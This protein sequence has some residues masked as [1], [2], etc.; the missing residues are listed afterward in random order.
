MCHFTSCEFNTFRNNPDQISDRWCI[1]HTCLLT[2]TSDTWLKLLL[3][4]QKN[5]L[6]K[7]AIFYKAVVISTHLRGATSNA[8]FLKLY[9]I[10]YFC[11]SFQLFSNILASFRR[12]DFIPTRKGITEILTQNRQGFCKRRSKSFIEKLSDFIFAGDFGHEKNKLFGTFYFRNQ[13]IWARQ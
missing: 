11:T 13:S 7:S 6:A 10:L 4:K 12:G 3:W 8:C 9:I 5:I 2:S 1:I